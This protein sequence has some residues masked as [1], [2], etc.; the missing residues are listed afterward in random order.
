MRYG[1]SVHYA[2]NPRMT[3]MRKKTTDIPPRKISMGPI[4]E[5]TAET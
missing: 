4:M 5:R 3:Q 2:K 1:V